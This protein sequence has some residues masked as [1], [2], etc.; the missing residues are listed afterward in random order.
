MMD[1]GLGHDGACGTRQ[2]FAHGARGFAMATT[3]RGCE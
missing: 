1:M 3:D 2:K